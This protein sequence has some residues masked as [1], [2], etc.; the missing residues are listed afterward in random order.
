MPAFQIQLNLLKLLI[1]EHFRWEFNIL[2]YLRHVE[3]FTANQRVAMSELY[4]SMSI[5]QPFPHTPI[6]YS[7]V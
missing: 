3:N 6:N 5:L 2:F 4:F 7:L 1:A